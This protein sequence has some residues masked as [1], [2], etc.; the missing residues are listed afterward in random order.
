MNAA[1]MTWWVFFEAEACHNASIGLPLNI[2]AAEFQ[3]KQDRVEAMSIHFYTSQI[4]LEP[5]SCADTQCY[6]PLN[7]TI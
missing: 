6:P 4:L 5:D 2:R 1:C 3:C 7:N